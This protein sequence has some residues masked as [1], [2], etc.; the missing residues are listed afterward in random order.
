MEGTTLGRTANAGNK[1]AELCFPMVTCVSGSRVNS[2]SL[3][4][5]LILDSISLAL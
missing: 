2:L 4:S 1:G 5:L 3:V